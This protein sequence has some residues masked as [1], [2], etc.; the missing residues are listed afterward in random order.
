MLLEGS[1]LPVQRGAAVRA[2]SGEERERG[3]ER[4]IHSICQL[5]NADTCLMR[6]YPQR[7]IIYNI[8]SKGGGGD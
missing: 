8:D 1:A 4:F 6:T 7:A 2:V 3:R 5:D